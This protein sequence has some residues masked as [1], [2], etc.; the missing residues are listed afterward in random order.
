PPPAATIRRNG[1]QLLNLVNQMLDLAKL[2]SG[3]LHLHLVHGDVVAFLKYLLESFQS[4]AQARQ[5]SLHFS[6]DAPSFF[7]DFDPEKLQQIVGNLL[8][9]AIKFTPAGGEVR[10]DASHLS[11]S[12]KLSER[13]LEGTFQIRVVD[14]GKGI[15]QEDLPRIFD[16][17]YQGENHQPGTGIG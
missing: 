12:L 10:L 9:N 3:N 1:Q 14:T 2:E 13:S 5:I 16:R 8:S 11:E 4:L 6:A 17:F 15:A 7:M